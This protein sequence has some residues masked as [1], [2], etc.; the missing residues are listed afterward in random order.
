MEFEEVL[1]EI[2]D[3]GIFQRRLVYWFLLPATVPLAWF[4]LNQIFMLSVPD[5]WC[6][7]PELS[8]SNLSVQQQQMLI[9]PIEIQFGLELPSQCRMYDL[10]YTSVL[11]D[12]LESPYSNITF[13]NYTLASDVPKKACQNGWA[14]DRTLYDSTASTHWDLVCEKDHLP[15]LIFTLS[16]VG[17]AVATPIYGAM[18]DRI[19]RKLTFFICV[20]VTLSSGVIS[21]VLPSFIAFAVF[22]LINGS[23]IPTIFQVPYIMLVEIV[24]KEK[25]TQMMGIACIGWTTG[26]CILPLLAFLIPN[27][28]TFGLVTTCFCI[29]YFF[30]WR[31]LPESPRWL[32]SIQRYE[33]AVVILTKMAKINGRSVPTDLVKRLKKVEESMRKE[34]ESSTTTENFTVLFRYPSLRKYFLTITISWVANSMAYY[35]LQ[36]NVTNLYGNEF[37]NFFLLGI[38][39]LPSYFLCW[40]LMERCGRRWTNVG[41][42]FLAALSILIPTAFP[43][44]LAIGTTIG[45]LIGKFGC[46]AAFMVVYQQA[47]ELYPTPVRALGMGSS[48]TIACIATICTPYIIYLGTYGRHIPYFIIGGTCLF[49]S[50]AASLLPE[51]LHAKLPQTIEDGEKY[52]QNQKYFSCHSPQDDD[53]EDD[54]KTDSVVQK[55][56][57]ELLSTV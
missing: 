54:V 55:E 7:V 15:H 45:A 42:M 47:A 49:A 51:T 13:Q 2:G 34:K 43:Q 46:S 38:V 18:S 9:R 44:D 40:Y 56:I 29:P 10:N 39:E 23:L 50:G 11:L 19:G 25:R 1:N 48:A 4:A 6:Y 22:R 33:E 5:H 20:T 52:G 24:G 31:F 14:Y 53:V 30:Y 36:I 27:W 21:L 12:F 28:K 8:E 37:L 16:S 35:G 3:Y 17:A 41:L 32:V 26:L 57:M